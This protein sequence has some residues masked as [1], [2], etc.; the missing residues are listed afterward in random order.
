MKL[1]SKQKAMKPKGDE[2]P[3]P[4]EWKDDV[5]MDEAAEEAAWVAQCAATAPVAIGQAEQ[6]EPE[7]YEEEA[8]EEDT[9]HADDQH[10]DQDEE[11]RHDEESHED[12]KAEEMEDEEKQEEEE[13]NK[14]L[15]A[16]EYEDMDKDRAK[17]A[18]YLQNEKKRKLSPDDTKDYDATD[19]TKDNTK[20][21]DQDHGWKCRNRNKGY[22]NYYGNKGGYGQGYGRS[23]WPKGKGK[24]KQKNKGKYNKWQWSQS[25]D[26]QWSGGK[27]DASS[28]AGGGPSSVLR[29]DNKGGYYLPH[30]QGY[31]DAQM[32]YHPHLALFQ[33]M[34]IPQKKYCSRGATF[35]CRLSWTQLCNCTL[36]SFPSLKQSSSSIDT[37]MSFS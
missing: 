37:L 3:I 24:G 13:S 2:D 26:W 28:H 5:E 1:L 31:I 17:L 25:D 9:T 11:Q 19:D 10:V 4:Q 21:A 36:M 8:E 33:C 29:A 27:G 34:L 14:S 18:K 20:D 22:G 16:K 12:E 35:E 30:G 32:Q 6:M 23:W 15:H 7:T